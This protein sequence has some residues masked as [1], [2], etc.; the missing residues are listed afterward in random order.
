MPIVGGYTPVP[1]L[2]A[3]GDGLMEIVC[4]A[5]I[6]VTGDGAR[7]VHD[8]II[9]ED[10]IRLFLNGEYLT[11]LVASPDRLNDLG[12]AGG[13]VVCE[14]LAETVESVE[15]SEKDVYITAPGEKGR[16]A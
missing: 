6:Q 9:V 14:G 4:R 5:G 3:G 12:G 2:D 7:E 11:A 15:V 13:F 16:P 10:H 1:R 8:D